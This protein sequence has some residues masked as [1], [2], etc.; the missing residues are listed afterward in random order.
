MKD[1][2]L[3]VGIQGQYHYY[4]GRFSGYFSRPDWKFLWQ[5]CFGLLENG[6]VKLSK[7]AQALSEGISMK[8]TTERLASHLGRVGFWGRILDGLLRVQRRA[9]RGC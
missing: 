8:K 4:L 1:K 6:E 7:I 2:E 9:L 3:L 5:M